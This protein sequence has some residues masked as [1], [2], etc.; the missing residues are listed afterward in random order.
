MYGP[1]GSRADQSRRPI[2]INPTPT[3]APTTALAIS[4]NSAPCQPTNAP[5][6]AMNFTSPN[7]IASRGMTSSSVSTLMNGTVSGSN[8]SSPISSRLGDS[9]TSASTQQRSTSSIRLACRRIVS[10]LRK[11]ISSYGMTSSGRCNADSVK[12]ADSPSSSVTRTL[13]NIS[14]PSCNTAKTAPAPTRMPSPLAISESA[15][16][17][18]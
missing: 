7:P 10:E 8:D 9:A 4:E 17:S 13:P 3:T 15:G 11:K 5:M 18:T 12:I 1:Y 14:L 6:A 2:A 16:R